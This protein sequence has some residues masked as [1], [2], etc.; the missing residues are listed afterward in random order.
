MYYL[1]WSFPVTFSS[2]R[3]VMAYI[4]ADK[5]RH[6]FALRTT[7]TVHNGC[8]LDD[9]SFVVQESEQSRDVTVNSRPN[10]S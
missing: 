10:T 4:N 7:F 5:G 3:H 2:R 1:E 9:H 6:E 8:A